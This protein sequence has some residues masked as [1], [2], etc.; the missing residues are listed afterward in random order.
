[1]EKGQ[2]KLLR[3][4][5]LLVA[6]TAI[7][8][9][10]YFVM[11]SLINEIPNFFDPCHTFGAEHPLSFSAKCPTKVSGTSESRLGVIIRLIS[12]QVSALVGAILGVVG[13]YIFSIRLSAISAGYLLYL[14][15]PLSIGGGSFGVYPIWSGITILIAMIIPK[16]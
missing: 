16:K 14:F 1:M 5:A 9:V 11:G 13:I 3:K 4:A 12:F 6:L 10:G 8:P 15:F 7:L 2:D